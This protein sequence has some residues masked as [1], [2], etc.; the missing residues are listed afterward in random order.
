LSCR[1]TKS[2]AAPFSVLSCMK[3]SMQCFVSQPRVILRTTTAELFL[4]KCRLDVQPELNAT[5][6]V[7]SRT[8]GRKGAKN[9]SLHVGDHALDIVDIGC[10]VVMVR[11]DVQK[12]AFISVSG[13]PSLV[14]SR[15]V[16][17]VQIKAHEN[18][19]CHIHNPRL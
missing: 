11:S 4:H 13:I 19:L 7:K 18:R 9:K 1:Q 15:V 2:F 17:L 12:S 10:C 6:R 5:L 14:A 16:T 3:C 8:Q